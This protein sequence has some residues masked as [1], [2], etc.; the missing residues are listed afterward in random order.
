M[1]T[2]LLSFI[3]GNFISINTYADNIDSNI[4]EYNRDLLY[5]EEDYLPKYY[6]N[7]TSNFDVAKLD[8]LPSKVDL[9]E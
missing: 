2:T 3:L 9:S 8:D 4:E 1:L 7:N 6:S 5:S